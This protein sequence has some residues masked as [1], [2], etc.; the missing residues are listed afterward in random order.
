MVPHS[1]LKTPEDW[2]KGNCTVPQKAALS[3]NRPL[4]S[5]SN[6]EAS[7]PPRIQTK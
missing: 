1:S 3:F 6:V 5:L 7:A 2:E 4:E